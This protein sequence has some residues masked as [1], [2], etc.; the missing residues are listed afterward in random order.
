MQRSFTSVTAIPG[1]TN[2]FLS[3]GVSRDGLLEPETLA[4]RLADYGFGTRTITARYINERLSVRRR[5]DFEQRIAGL[6][7]SGPM[8]NSDRQPVLVLAALSYWAGMSSPATAHLLS[9]LVGIRLWPVLLFVVG[10]IIA[11]LFWRRRIRFALRFAAFSTGF[12]GAFASIL[13]LLLFQVSS[14][15]LHLHL[16]LLTTAFMAGTALGGAWATRR[17]QGPRSVTNIVLVGNRGCRRRRAGAARQ[18]SAVLVRTGGRAGRIR[19]AG[20]RGRVPARGRVSDYQ[21][22]LS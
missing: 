19:T 20:G 11:V 16:A 2:L 1:E 9:R 5:T 12:A 14:G 8:V 17:V 6:P 18:L 13:V 22:S 4:A 3:S 7:V 10:L 21:P 15:T